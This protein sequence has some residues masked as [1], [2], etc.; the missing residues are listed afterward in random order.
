MR[1]INALIDIV[2]VCSRITVT[3]AEWIANELYWRLS[4][5]SWTELIWFKREVHLW[6][7]R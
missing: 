6:K 4:L 3:V 1:W 7:L 5:I 2:L